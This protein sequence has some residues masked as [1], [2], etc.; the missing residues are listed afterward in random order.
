MVIVIIIIIIITMM[1]MM[2]MFL[3]MTVTMITGLWCVV[4]AVAAI[5]CHLG[6]YDDDFVL[7][8]DW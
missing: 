4:L 5:V 3:T 2:M 1:M 8:V 6:Y 7:D